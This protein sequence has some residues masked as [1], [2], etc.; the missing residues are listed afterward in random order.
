MSSEPQL[1]DEVPEDDAVIGRAFRA[2]VA[3]IA[4]VAA[5]VAGFMVLGAEDEPEEVV[6]EK[7]VGPIDDLEVD[8]ET[9]PSVRFTDVTESAG[10]TFVHEAGAT[11]EKLLP[12]TMGGGAA[13]LDFDGDGDQDLF[14]VNGRRWSLGPDDD[15]ASSNALY[16]N[17]GAGRFEDVTDAVG[18][19]SATYGMGAAVGDYDGDGRVDVFTTGVGGNRL[20]RN[21]GGRFEDVT[22]AAGVGGSADAWTTSAGFFD[23]DGDD[24][25]DLFVCHYV[26][27]SPEIDREIAY[28]LNG[29]DRAYG[30]P[31]NYAG[32]FSTLFRNEGD[33]TF[34]DASEAAGIH[35][36]NAAT[37]APMGKALGVVFTDVDEDGHADVL[38]ANDTVQN[39]LFRGLGDG[40]FEEIGA[41][42]GFGFDGNGG[43]TGAMG[44]DLGDFRGDGALGVCIGNFANEMSSLFVKRPNRLRF[45]DDAMGEGVGS[46]SRRRLSFGMFFFDYDLDGRLDLLQVNG[47]LEESIHEVQPSQTYLQPPQLFW[48]QG[49]D[50]RACFAEVPADTTGDLGRDLAGRGSAYADIDGDGD[51]DVVLCQVGRR[52]VLLRNDQDL[53]R[54][55]L[56]VRLEQPGANRFALGA[57][58]AVT[59][60][61]GVL[62]REVTAT[63]SYLSQSELPQT[64]G[65]GADATVES[66]EV[67]WPDGARQAVEVPGSLDREIAVVRAN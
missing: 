60:S 63:R 41:R 17:D 61:A 57:R 7:D 49:P 32:T 50:A 39:H 16:R 40:T 46:P 12:E 29:E 51:L 3:V 59:T 62:R 35:V 36:T 64:F 28:S 33:G 26:R 11:E 18:L 47:H 1:H 44:I 8:V 24:D 43:A 19:T 34:V 14:L 20:Y 31:M 55:W 13:F 21:A 15:V 65:L 5:A 9:L 45:T 2:S 23:A 53:G 52:P 58:I 54:R 67:T 27:W 42:S 66:I 37:G 30:P 22:D 48:N 6:R 56:R 38:V 4:V 10:I 25:L